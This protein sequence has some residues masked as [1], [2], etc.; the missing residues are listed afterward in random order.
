ML[1]VAGGAQQDHFPG[2]SHQMAARIAAE[3]GDRS[4][5]NAAVTRIE[6][7]PDAVLVTSSNGVVEA[8]RAIS[9]SHR[10]S[11][12]TSTSPRVAD[13]IP[14]AGPALSLGA[15]TKSYAAYPTPFW[16]AKGLR[17][18]VVGRGPRVHHVATSA[19]ARAG[20]GILLAFTDGA[21]IRPAGTR[22]ASRAGP[23]RFR[24]RCS[25]RKPCAAH[26]LHRPTLGRQRVSHPAALPRRCCPGRGRSSARC[27][28]NRSACCDWAAPRR[29]TNGPG[30]A[31]MRRCAWQ[32]GGRR[33][34]RPR[35]SRRSQELMRRSE[36]TADTMARRWW[37][38]AR[39]PAAR[40]ARPASPPARPGWAPRR[41]SCGP[42]TSVAAGPWYRRSP[43]WA[44]VRPDRSMWRGPIS[45]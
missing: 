23:G 40:S 30:L 4:G 44:T 26:R 21:P 27:C 37:L 43:G 42:G 8:R 3:L 45:R 12:L 9:P 16:R 36:S 15:L 10:P 39:V 28:A 33:G 2:G 29:P 14:T 24:P 41:R 38:T 7:S 19:P 5:W 17:A 31:W 22:R 18:G 11:G 32:R 35:S 20:P 1:D 34:G 6:W 25:A 13:R